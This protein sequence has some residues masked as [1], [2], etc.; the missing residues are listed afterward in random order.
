MDLSK[1]SLGDKIIGGAALVYLISMFLP[2][3]TID[4]DFLGSADAN[5]FDVGFLWGFFPLL[6]AIVMVVQIVLDK[7]T[8]TQLPEI[9]ATW[10]QVHLGLGGLAALLVVLKLL[11]GES[12]P[13]SRSFGLFLATL[14]AIG[15]AV[16]GFFKMQ[17]EGGTA[18]TGSSSPPQ[19]F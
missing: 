3:F 12:D 5:G 18:T 16:G 7:M 13:W 4:L 14:A 10:G 19:S 2:W 17:E 9:P 1:L 8:T 11:I 15:L 6:L